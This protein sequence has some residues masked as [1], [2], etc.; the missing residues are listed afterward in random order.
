MGSS[1]TK[2]S[3]RLQHLPCLQRTAASALTRRA[4]AQTVLILKSSTSSSLTLRRNPRRGRPRNTRQGMPAP[5]PLPPVTRSRKALRP[6][7]SRA[8]MTGGSR[9]CACSRV[10]GSQRIGE[11]P[12][13]R[14]DGM[15]V[16]SQRLLVGLTSLPR[17]CLVRRALQALAATEEANHHDV[18][19]WTEEAQTRLAIDAE[20]EGEAAPS[21]RA[22]QHT[23]A[24]PRLTPGPPAHCRGEGRPGGS[25]AGVA[26]GGGGQEGPEEA[27]VR[28]D[29]GGS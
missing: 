23:K 12:G 16:R 10:W 28:P 3:A 13:A 22:V 14:G 1:W 6:R 18:L 5:A 20:W 19:L 17:R 15:R 27:S 25:D 21:S 29:P 26:G 4:R 8:L 9:P 2:A 11:E 24:L 7:A